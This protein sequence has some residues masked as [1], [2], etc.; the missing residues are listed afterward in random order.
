MSTTR[1]GQWA[2]AYKTDKNVLQTIPQSQNLADALIQGIGDD[3]YLY[4]DGKKC[5]KSELT[6]FRDEL[7]MLSAEDVEQVESPEDKSVYQAMN[8]T[9][10]LCKLCYFWGWREKCFC[11]LIEELNCMI[12]FTDL[13]NSNVCT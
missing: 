10:E 5:R 12:V 8:T 13:S 11:F 7:I 4:P 1:T 9:F 3:M 2:I 6:K